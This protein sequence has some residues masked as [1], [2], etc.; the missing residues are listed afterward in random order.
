M[1]QKDS[2]LQRQLP[3]MMVPIYEPLS[4]IAPGAARLL[5]AKDGLWIEADA[6][7]G[8][9]RKQL[10]ESPRDL[11]YGPIEELNALRCGRIP[12]RYLDKF[13]FQANEEAER[14]CETA[15]WIIWH[16]TIGWK[17]HRLE[18]L[19]QS[20]VSVSYRWPQLEPEWH[21]IL[22]MHSHGRISAFFSS[23]DE[24]SD[25]GNP[26]FSMVFGKCQRGMNR[27]DLDC[28]LR[29]CIASFYFDE[30]DSDERGERRS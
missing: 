10:W 26:H 16:P 19:D 27:A 4:P 1:N 12:T 17:Y 6:I 28:E 15:A 18:F 24:R 8:H 23:T 3:T 21:L 22:D 7:W 29:L 30:E 5:M 9:F 13:A 20:A 11:P 14:G 2:I 25:Q